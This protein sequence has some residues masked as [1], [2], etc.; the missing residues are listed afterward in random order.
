MFLLVLPGTVIAERIINYTTL[1]LLFKISQNYILLLYMIVGFI[2]FLLLITLITYTQAKKKQGVFVFII[3]TFSVLFGLA[4]PLFKNYVSNPIDD[5]LFF[6]YGIGYLPIIMLPIILGK[7]K[8]LTFRT[9]K[10]NL[11]NI[12]FLL[13]K[14][15]CYGYLLL[16]CIYNISKSDKIVASYVNI[17][18]NL[19]VQIFSILLSIIFF[20]Y[21]EKIIEISGNKLI[22]LRAI[23]IK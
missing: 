6:L 7:V 22:Q 13:Y 2:L 19:F 10:N 1:Y 15:L 4:S 12:S 9:I 18:N 20:T 21:A 3:F 5:L 8:D 23:F 14:V 16:F 11:G 17:H